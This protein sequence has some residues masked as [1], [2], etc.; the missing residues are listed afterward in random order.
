M[1]AASVEV[2]VCWQLT[3]QSTCTSPL[4][5]TWNQYENCDYVTCSPSLK[6]AVTVTHMA[7]ALT[8]RLLLERSWCS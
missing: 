8:A 1:V 6:H 4:Q 7:T 5:T 2:D 3:L